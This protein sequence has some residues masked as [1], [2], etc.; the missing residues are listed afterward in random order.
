MRVAIVTEHEELRNLR[1]HILR[2]SGFEPV[3]PDS[4]ATA[5]KTLVDNPPEILVLCY[6][7]S[8]SSAAEFADVYKQVNENGKIVAITQG[9]WSDAAIAADA[10]VDGA[11]PAALLEVLGRLGRRPFIVKE[12]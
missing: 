8:S 4:R 7:L 10:V 5:L 11:D 9:S 6:T 3:C 1:A 2:V 12:E